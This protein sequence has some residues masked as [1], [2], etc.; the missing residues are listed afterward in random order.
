MH[1]TEAKGITLASDVSAWF[2][3]LIP[4]LQPAHARA[5]DPTREHLLLVIYIWVELLQIE[6][7]ADAISSQ[8]L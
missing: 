3:H 5:G 4:S 1:Y 6:P 2:S 8:G 7:H